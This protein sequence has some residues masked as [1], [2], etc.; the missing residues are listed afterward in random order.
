MLQQAQRKAARQFQHQE[1]NPEKDQN[2]RFDHGHSPSGFWAYDVRFTPRS[3]NV[4]AGLSQDAGDSCSFSLHYADC[5]KCDEGAGL[6]ARG[7][8]SPGWNELETHD[9]VLS[10]CLSEVA[11][12]TED[13]ARSARERILFGRDEIQIE[14]GGRFQGPVGGGTATS[15]IQKREIKKFCK[16]SKEEPYRSSLNATAGFPVTIDG[17]GGQASIMFLLLERTT[18]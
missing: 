17:D 5:A 12:N 7:A 3:D 18:A 15:N 16:E 8:G 14:T 9:A 10:E 13:R 6:R 1:R 11:Q 4:I 2:S